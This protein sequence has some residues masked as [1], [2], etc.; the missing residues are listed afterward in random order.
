MNDIT[1]IIENKPKFDSCTAQKQTKKVVNLKKKKKKSLTGY[2]YV[3][4]ED[5]GKCKVMI[6]L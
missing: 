3:T 1:L 5:N 6:C 2:Y 4:E